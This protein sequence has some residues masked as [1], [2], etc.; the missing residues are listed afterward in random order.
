MNVACRNLGQVSGCKRGFDSSDERD[1]DGDGLC[2]PCRERQRKIA[3]AVQAKVDSGGKRKYV[4]RLLPN[5]H[6]TGDQ[7]W[8][9]VRQLR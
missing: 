6:L 4:P 5:A 2:P 7:G 9:N 1:L 8:I 3:I